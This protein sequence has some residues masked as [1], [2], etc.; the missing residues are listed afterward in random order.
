MLPLPCLASNNKPPAMAQFFRNMMVWIES[1]KLLW[2]IKADNSV[3]KARHAAT[4]RVA[5]PMSSKMPAVISNMMV[6]NNN[7]A[8]KANVSI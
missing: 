4:G 6:G 5:H 7:H 8:G 1:E 3:K 2:K